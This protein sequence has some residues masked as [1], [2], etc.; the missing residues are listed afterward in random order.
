MTICCILIGCYCWSAMAS[1]HVHSPRSTTSLVFKFVATDWPQSVSRIL[2][3]LLTT[4]HTHNHHHWIYVWIP[5]T[6]SFIWFGMLHIYA[7]QE[8]NAHSPD[9]PGTLFSMII[10]WKATGEPRY[11]SQKGQLPEISDVGASYLKPLFVTGGTITA[12]GFFLSLV[13]ERWLRHSGR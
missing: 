9:L 11:P 1:P 2:I 12:V 4:M 3:C 6:A 5:L 7:L 13:A 10:T 8:L